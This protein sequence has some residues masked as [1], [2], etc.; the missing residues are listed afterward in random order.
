MVRAKSITS[1]KNLHSFHFRYNADAP[2]NP[3]HTVMSNIAAY[4]D[5]GGLVTVSTYLGMQNFIIR[6]VYSVLS[7]SVSVSV[8]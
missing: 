5:E 6:H 2:N 4:L 3:V 8:F 7:V 1:L